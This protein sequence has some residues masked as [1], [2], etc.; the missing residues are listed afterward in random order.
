MNDKYPQEWRSRREIPN[1][2]IKDT[3]DQYEQARLL[4][5][6]QPP[7]TGILLPLMNVAAT[8]IEL[9]L[10]SLAGE[11]IHLPEND[12]LQSYVVYAQE[13]KGR[14]SFGD[15]LSLLDEN[16]RCDMESTYVNETRRQ[17]KD[18]LGA[19][20]SA[21]VVTRYPYEPDMDFESISLKTLMVI[22]EFLQRFVANMEPRETIHWKDGTISTVEYM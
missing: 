19:I 21:L 14:H 11:V 2:Q 9:Y 13:T 3:A 1:P 20:E 10:K 12:D 8:A 5:S 22:S 7:E 4:L 6:T 17:L 18:D 15:I 16:V